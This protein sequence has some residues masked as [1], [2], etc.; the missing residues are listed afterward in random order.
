MITEYL[1]AATIAVTGV[2]LPP[3]DAVAGVAP[4]LADA[5]AGVAPPPADVAAGVAP[6]PAES[7]SRW[8]QRNARPLATVDPRASLTDLRHL[9]PAIGDAAIV[10][11][12]EATHGAAEITT[13]KHRVLR[14]LVEDLGYRTV[15]WEEDWSLGLLINDYLRT[16]AGDLPGLVS[17][18]STAWRSREVTDVLRWIRAWNATHRDDDDVTFTGVEAYGTRPLIYQRVESYVASRAPARLDEA[19]AHLRPLTPKDDNMQ[20]HVRWYWLDVTDKALYLRHARELHELVAAVPHAPGDRTHELHLHHARQIAGFY[21]QFADPNPYAYRDAHA[22]K[23]LR[24]TQQFTGGRVA[25]W[26]ASG[27]TLDGPQLRL[28][29][30]PYPVLE[31][32]NVGSFIRDWYGTGYRSLGFTVD[33]GAVVADGQVVTMPPAAPDWLEA[34][35]AEVRADQFTLDLRAGAP[36]LVRRWLTGPTRTRGLPAAGAESY[37]AGGSPGQWFDVLV[38]RQVVTPVT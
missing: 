30:P 13:L 9:R 28:T 22:A 29:Q 33:R 24:W 17:Q 3:A 23:N 18:M 21:E 27:H 8:A 20:E 36:P 7:V 10:G 5:V 14:L 25:Y 34:P 1:L 35:M 15:A 16:G 38:H 26:A 31:I 19:R 32:A 2:T 6:P 37:L 11:L 4:P 12:G